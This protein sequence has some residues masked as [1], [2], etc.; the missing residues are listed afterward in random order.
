MTENRAAAG[1]SDTPAPLPSR[2]RRAGSGWRGD[3]QIAV[4]IAVLVLGGGVTLWILRSSHDKPH[5][6]GLPVTILSLSRYTGPNAATD[7]ANMESQ[8]YVDSGGNSTPLAGLY[9]NLPGGPAVA[10]VVQTP[11]G[12]SSCVLP[13]SSQIV[14]SMKRSGDPTVR[15]F[16]LSGGI[17]VCNTFRNSDQI[18]CGWIDQVTNG[19]AFFA[20]G[21]ASSLSDAADKTTRIVAAIEN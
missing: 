4:V 10:V 8:A 12:G 9:G 15:T 16:A 5:K 18:H 17:M 3:W 20:S 14:Q 7:E 13:T 11:C 1:T 6:I 2:R 21:F 19:S